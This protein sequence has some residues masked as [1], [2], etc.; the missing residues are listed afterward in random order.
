M[1]VLIR[2][3]SGAFHIFVSKLQ[4]VHVI[5]RCDGN[6]LEG[7]MI[8]SVG[9]PH[10]AQIYHFVFFELILFLELDKQLP[11]EQFEAAVSQSTLPSSRLKP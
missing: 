6:V 10:R 3:S 5:D 1:S 4:Q 11:V 8:R 9:N 7:G 2:A